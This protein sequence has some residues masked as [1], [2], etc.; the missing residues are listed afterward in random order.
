MVVIHA[1]VGTDNFDCYVALVTNLCVSIS[2]D[3]STSRIRW[4]S[5]HML[6]WSHRIVLWSKERKMQGDCSSCTEYKSTITVNWSPA[7]LLFFSPQTCTNEPNKNR[8]K[9]RVILSVARNYLQIIIVFLDPV[10][11]P[12][13]HRMPPSLKSRAWQKYGNPIDDC[14]M[15]DA[16]W[17]KRRKR[18]ADCVVGYAEGTTGG[19]GGEY[20]VVNTEEDDLK[21]PR[22]GM[23]RHAVTQVWCCTSYSNRT[24][25][26][27]ASS[28][29]LLLQQ[30]R[31][32]WAVSLCTEKCKT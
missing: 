24:S 16:E 32:F 11:A 3:F 13:S 8:M 19:A 17:R 7:L 6:H 31:P 12:R 20:Y 29:K 2:W 22:P 25:C 4:T 27:E 18:L 23:L 5:N 15:G 30:E 21:Y 26:L 14:W 28:Y 10:T 9:S 1:W